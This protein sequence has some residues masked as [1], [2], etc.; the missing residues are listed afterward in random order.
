MLGEIH[1][2]KRD[3]DVSK[4]LESGASKRKSQLEKK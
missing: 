4:N 3:R 2:N 1:G